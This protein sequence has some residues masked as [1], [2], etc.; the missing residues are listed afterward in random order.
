VIFRD[1]LRKQA[2]VAEEDDL[3]AFL[4][5]NFTGNIIIF[6]HHLPRELRDGERE[7]GQ[8]IPFLSGCDGCSHDKISLNKQLVIFV[9]ELDSNDRQQDGSE[10]RRRGRGAV[11]DCESAQSSSFLQPKENLKPLEG[12]Q[13]EGIVI[14]ALAMTQEEGQWMSWDL[15]IGVWAKEAQ[16][17]DQQQQQ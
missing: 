14:G 13:A 4:S 16:E 17:F 9:I 6:L 3:I 11:E 15:I 10:R 8:R 5:T 2:E 7:T 12:Q 1:S